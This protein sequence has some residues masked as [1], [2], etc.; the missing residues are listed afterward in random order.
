MKVQ[1]SS[2][3]PGNTCCHSK[4]KRS[5]QDGK[6]VER[7]LE[8]SK[9]FK[10]KNNKLHM[11]VCNIKLI[12]FAK[13]D[14]IASDY[15]SFFSKSDL[16]IIRKALKT[17]NEKV[18]NLNNENQSI[19][20]NQTSPKKSVD[21][22][23]DV[24]N[25]RKRTKRRPS[26]K[27]EKSGEPKIKK[28]RKK[29]IE[30]KG[31]QMRKTNSTQI[32][33]E[34][35]NSSTS[36]ECISRPKKK[37]YI[38]WSDNSTN[39]TF[40]N[41]SALEGVLVD[42][43][44]EDHI[45][46][47]STFKNEKIQENSDTITLYGKDSCPLSLTVNNCD[48][49]LLLE[50]NVRNSYKSSEETL[51]INGY[52]VDK[53]TNS[54]NQY[55][56]LL[57]PETI[58][59]IQNNNGLKS[60]ETKIAT[61]TEQ[62]VN[63]NNKI[64]ESSFYNLDVGI[65]KK[66]QTIPKLKTNKEQ[67]LLQ[68]SQT[69]END[70][71]C[72]SL[73]AES[74]FLFQEEPT[75]QIKGSVTPQSEDNY[76][77]T[78]S[79]IDI[80]ME[81]NK[82]ECTKALDSIGNNK[83]NKEQNK[84]EIFTQ[85]VL[86]MDKSAKK[87]DIISFVPKVD[88]NK[89]YNSHFKGYCF[90]VLQRGDCEWGNKCSYIHNGLQLL[91]LCPED[92]KSILE[93][94]KT[95]R[96]RNFNYFVKTICTTVFQNRCLKHEEIIALYKIIYE[97]GYLDR[98][99]INKTVIALRKI[100]MDLKQIVSDLS[101]IVTD[102]NRVIPK[103]IFQE[104]ERFV[105]T[106]KYW[107][108][109]KHLLT[110]CIPEKYQVEKV[111]QECL[112]INTDLKSIQ[113]VN[114]N[115]ISKLPG[116]YKRIVDAKLFLSFNKILNANNGVANNHS[117]L[118]VSNNKS[119][120]E[121][122]DT[123]SP[124]SPG[125]TDNCF[126][127]LDN[128]NSLSNI[129][130]LSPE[131]LPNPG[132]SIISSY[133]LHP[134][135]DLPEP[136]SIYRDKFWKFYLDLESLKEGLKH[137]DYDYVIGILEKT[138][139]TVE[140]KPLFTNTCYQILKSQIKLSQHH[141][142][143]IIKRTVQ[144]RYATVQEIITEAALLILIDL[145]EDNLWI[146]AYKLLKSLQMY[147]IEVDAKFAILSAEINLALNNPIKA[148][149]ILRQYNIIFTNRDKW[150]VKSTSEDEIFRKFVMNLLLEMLCRSS[151]EH[152]FFLVEFL[153]KDQISCFYP[154][155]ISRYASILV[156]TVLLTKNDSIAIEM[157]NLLINYNW[158]ISPKSIRA[159]I[160]T[161]VHIEKTLAQRLYR[162]AAYLGIY[163]M[164]KISPD[165]YMTINIDWTE[166]EIYLALLEMIHTISLELG[167]CFKNMRT[168]QL[169]VYLIFEFMET[170]ELSWHDSKK[171]LYREKLRKIRLLTAKVLREKFYPPLRMTKIQHNRLCKIVGKSLAIHLV[172]K[173]T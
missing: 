31:K 165:L 136:R 106:G 45:S 50:E 143:N 153:L 145:V 115:F 4:K 9:N 84:K 124:G 98:D 48:K 30:N 154:I 29:D 78:G 164:L 33:I 27:D 142:S 71:D 130:N 61:L 60:V 1:K 121:A 100:N 55:K 81:K 28:R 158:I 97:S 5:V 160:A 62:N 128:K 2:C 6:N 119:N 122:F 10:F 17:L 102:S 75:I 93:F 69:A 65:K 88:L 112:S 159:L 129:E 49:L 52:Q 140:Q 76:S 89:N 32:S 59:S 56:S 134:I 108:T 111:L 19:K 13:C 92:F 83:N 57:I 96:D 18:K 42:T 135:K 161:L 148:L 103:L 139:H 8:R 37:T 125:S 157:G 43:A 12:D 171:L 126:S 123:I 38:D 41:C 107:E 35:D 147:H 63:I 170:E 137:Y 23:I 133:T 151:V 163:G 86:K 114:N 173:N 25:K 118:K 74:L 132:E 3:I 150:S 53:D 26:E 64:C 109:F 44:K 131:V 149:N 168:T 21:N 24:V 40:K 144:T 105:N 90:R 172:I 34:N 20:L 36:S 79:M 99:S 67:N 116:H 117:S 95:A 146:L 72:I 73:Y 68:E 94:I 127:K 39:S 80:Y 54:D 85:N 162:Y 14:F 110:K 22:L 138:L 58:N 70:S 104:V 156:S 152:A 16:D 51:C 11:E 77:M 113:D 47:A 7:K 46:N 87:S 166:E 141:L 155:D 101:L 82:N 91:Q 167:F 15:K 169:S 66:L 120:R